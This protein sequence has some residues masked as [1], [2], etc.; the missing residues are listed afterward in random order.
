MKIINNSGLFEVG[1]SAHTCS[2]TPHMLNT[3]SQSYIFSSCQIR[4]SL[5][6]RNGSDD[7][8]EREIL[9]LQFVVAILL[10]M[11]F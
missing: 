10:D 1:V 3:N 6:E 5:N 11:D 9:P 8:W 2:V 7:Q 4:G